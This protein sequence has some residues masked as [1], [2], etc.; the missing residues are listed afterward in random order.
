MKNTFICGGNL[1]GNTSCRDRSSGKKPQM[2]CTHWLKLKSLNLKKLTSHMWTM[3]CGYD[4]LSSNVQLLNGGRNK[5]PKKKEAHHFSIFV[6]VN[7][8]ST[9][10]LSGKVCFK[11]P[12]C[13]KGI[14]ADD[15][16][17]IFPAEENLVL[18]NKDSKS[19]P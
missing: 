13:C 9:K 6:F 3:I 19:A 12:H 14:E 2:D 5:W 16:F 7:Q 1:A 11:G 15:N 17:S 8:H 10:F 4:L 18:N